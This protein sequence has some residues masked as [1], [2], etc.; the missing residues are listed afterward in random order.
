MFFLK[1]LWLVI[2]YERFNTVAYSQSF[3]TFC[4]VTFATLQVKS[5]SLMGPVGSVIWLRLSSCTGKIHY[6]VI[7]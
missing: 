3:F 6:K 5:N 1:V 4:N 7:S 2:S